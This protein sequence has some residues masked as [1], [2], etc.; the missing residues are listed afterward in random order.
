M[1]RSQLT[2]AISFVRSSRSPSGGS[3]RS[4]STSPVIPLSPC[5]V[6]RTPSTPNSPTPSSPPTRRPSLPIYHRRPDDQTVPL[7]ACCPNCV[8]ITEECLKEG[9]TWTEKFTKGA[10]RRRSA[11]LDSTGTGGGV[12]MAPSAS[13]SIGGKAAFVPG[14]YDEPMP[15][16]T[17]ALTVD[18]VDKRRK[19]LDGSPRSISPINRYPHTTRTTAFNI[20]DRDRSTD[21]ILSD[22]S[23]QSQRDTNPRPEQP[24]LLPIRKASPI[25]EED[26]N[27]LFPL[28]SP[29]RSPSSSS[30]GSSPK[31]SPRASPKSSPGVSPG[32]SPAPSPNASS[33]CLHPSSAAVLAAALKSQ[34]KD[35]RNVT[36][37]GNL[38][39]SG[40]EEK[41]ASNGGISRKGKGKALMEGESGRVM[42]VEEL[43]MASPVSGSGASTPKAGKP[44]PL[45]LTLA[46]PSTR[47]SNTTGGDTAPN[48]PTSPSATVLNPSIS[49][50]SSQTKSP[51]TPASPR[52]ASSPSV[53][54][55][56]KN[57]R[58]TVDSSNPTHGGRKLSF[59][60]PFFKAGEAIKGASVDVLKGVSSISSGGGMMG[61]V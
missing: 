15:P 61:G 37:K 17:F 6:S 1:Y 54:N 25:A 23:D 7:R 3:A 22:D 38:G 10:R 60:L 18:E 8:P 29:R 4:P 2:L 50:F 21:S 56:G 13:A 11:S 46:F 53:S 41:L 48:S 43:D 40:S 42:D 57:N 58:V 59:T 19:S 51:L 44:R 30:A 47:K 16:P 12:G 35:K 32:Q 52:L 55:G 34:S 39:S 20:H 9:S 45:S 24:T 33:S 26:E 28:P 14:S 27:E 5:L 49:S 31:I 36:S